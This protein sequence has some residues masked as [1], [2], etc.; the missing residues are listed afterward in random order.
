MPMAVPTSTVSK[1]TLRQFRFPPSGTGATRCL[2]TSISTLTAIWCL[3][4]ASTRSPR[5]PCSAALPTSSY[6]TRLK[7]PSAS[8]RARAGTRTA[9]AMWPTAGIRRSTVPLRRLTRRAR[10]S[11]P[12]RTRTTT[13]TSSCA[14][15]TISA[16][17]TTT[18]ANTTRKT[19]G[20]RSSLSRRSPT[21]CTRRRTSRRS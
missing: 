5:E 1:P 21:S 15:A 11:T 18:T 13:N 19:S 4:A 12:I 16:S 14:T 10:R 8:I 7:R 17:G 20:Q 2:T 6:T 3:G 9:T